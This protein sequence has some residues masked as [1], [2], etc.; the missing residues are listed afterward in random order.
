MA[1]CETSQVG[2]QWL[3]LRK[4]VVAIIFLDI[5]EEDERIQNRSGKTR[6]WIRRWEEK[7]YFNNTIQ[8]LMINDSPVYCEMM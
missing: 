5:L 4:S 8:E 6:G 2:I 3:E 7:R 1:E